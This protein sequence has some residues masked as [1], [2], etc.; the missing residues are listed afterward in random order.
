[1]NL[2]GQL[3]WKPHLFYEVSL[4]SGLKVGLTLTERTGWLILR[5]ES[6]HLSQGRTKELPL[7]KGPRCPIVGLSPFPLFL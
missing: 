3:T 2:M 7:K 4:V 5:L 6:S 1:M